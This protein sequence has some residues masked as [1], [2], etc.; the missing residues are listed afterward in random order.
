[1]AIWTNVPRAVW[2]FTASGYLVL[3]K[4]PSYREESV[5]GCS[6]TTGEAR[7]FTGIVR[8]IA[9]LVLLGRSLDTNYRDVAEARVARLGRA[10]M[11][12]RNLE[13]AMT[14]RLGGQDWLPDSPSACW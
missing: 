2:E 8:W 7:D 6:L 10:A 13:R 5:L 4:W 1:V 14:A 12:A 9:A 3:K 11:A